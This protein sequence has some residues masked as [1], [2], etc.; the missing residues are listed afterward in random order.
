MGSEWGSINIRANITCKHSSNIAHETLW[1]RRDERTNPFSLLRRL[2]SS[3]SFSSRLASLLSLLI[4]QCL[5]SSFA[6]QNCLLSL[7]DTS[8][9]NEEDSAKY[10]WCLLMCLFCWEITPPDKS[11]KKKINQPI[12]AS[13]HL[14]SSSICPNIPTGLHRDAYHMLKFQAVNIL[15]DET[16][17]WGNHSCYLQIYSRAIYSATNL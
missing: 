13:F 7:P 4:F 9:A 5:M 15:E 3:S 17:Y 12:P 1:S 14:H 8:F 16:C 2:S 10:T 6:W 11:F